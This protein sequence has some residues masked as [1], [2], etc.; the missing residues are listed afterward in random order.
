MIR[1]HNCKILDDNFDIIENNELWVEN[2]TIKYIGEAK[3]SLF[4]REIDCKGNLLMP[5]FKNAHT[6][7]PMTFLRSYADDL[8]LDRWLNEMIFPMEAKLTEDDAYYLSMLAAAEFVS[9]GITSAF[10]MYFY[11][12]AIAEAAKTT[13]FRTT[14]CGAV[15]NFTSSPEELEK[16]FEKYNCCCDTVTFRLGFHGEYTTDISIL[17]DIASLSH[18]YKAPVSAHCSETEKEVDQ[19]IQRHGKSPVELF[20][21]LG[22]SDFGGSL[23]HCVHLSERDIAILKEKDITVVTNPASNCKL[24]S[25]IAPL[26][27]LDKAGVRLAIGTD[28]PAS[29]NALSMFREMYLA[30]ALQKIQTKDASALVPEKVLEMACR[31]GAYAMSSNNDCLKEGKL[32]DIIMIDMDKPNMQP[33]N[34]IVKNI[35]YSGGNE[36]IAL[37]MVNG[38]ILYEKGNFFI[39]EDI[40][41]LYKKCAQITERIKKESNN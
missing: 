38:K 1:F 32:A 25:G 30:T 40:E 16:D 24:A 7:S 13:G 26:S 36:N 41:R 35:V 15:N 20:C 34:N 8:P 29:N 9:G 18:K 22:I 4:E 23:F 14:L 17:K 39:G 10:D 19:C 21:D 11:P 6:H 12:N 37:T 3:D 2:N 31:N 33:V 27:R 5:G 28:G